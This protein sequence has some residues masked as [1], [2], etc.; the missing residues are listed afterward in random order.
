MAYLARFRKL[1]STLHVSERPSSCFILLLGCRQSQETVGYRVTYLCPG[2]SR[3]SVAPH[4]SL[5]HSVC[6]GAGPRTG[7]S[8]CATPVCKRCYAGAMSAQKPE[9]GWREW[10]RIPLDRSYKAPIIPGGR[11]SLRWM[12]ALT[13][14]PHPGRAPRGD[15]RVARPDPHRSARRRFLPQPHART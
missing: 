3:L 13:R 14:M 9:L 2:A 1:H 10:R 11:H 5:R 12:S 8:T 6:G 7:Q 15:V 4:G